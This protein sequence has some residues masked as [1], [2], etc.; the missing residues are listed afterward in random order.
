MPVYF[1]QYKIL[2]A[3]KGQ[4]STGGFEMK[5]RLTGI[6][7]WKEMPKDHEYEWQRVQRLRRENHP[8]MK[9]GNYRDIES[10]PNL[11]LRKF[12]RGKGVKKTGYKRNKK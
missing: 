1:K 4:G 5:G 10:C 2:A 7:A 12:P 8:L 6:I 3:S 9:G 11:G